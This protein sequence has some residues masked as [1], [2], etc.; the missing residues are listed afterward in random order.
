MVSLSAL[1]KGAQ[2]FSR[3]EICVPLLAQSLVL[4]VADFLYVYHPIAGYGGGKEAVF[5]RVALLRL[6][7]GQRL[8]FADVFLVAG[9]YA[10]QFLLLERLE[11]IV[12]SRLA[13]CAQYVLAVHGV[14]HHAHPPVDALF[15]GVEECHSL[16]VGQLHVEK[17]YVGTQTEQELFARRS[18]GGGAGH[19]EFRMCSE[20]AVLSSSIMSAM[21]CSV[22][23]FPK[24][25]YFMIAQ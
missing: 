3:G 6:L 10:V 9:Y 24:G 19:G 15:Y 13:Q 7:C 14:E 12:E 1:S 4:E 17:Q 18:G 20:V 16:H 25:C 5:Q 11:Q 21:Y 8:R 2:R 22:S 23:I